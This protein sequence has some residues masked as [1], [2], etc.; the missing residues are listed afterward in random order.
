MV[1]TLADKLNPQEREA[2]AFEA[3]LIE[4]RASRAKAE[5]DF[6]IARKHADIAGAREMTP[7][8]ARAYDSA[9]EWER[10]CL[11]EMETARGD[12]IRALASDAAKRLARVSS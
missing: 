5:E 2:L 11:R 12:V 10:I 8:N 3:L 1:V 6:R 7:S 4:L 9:R